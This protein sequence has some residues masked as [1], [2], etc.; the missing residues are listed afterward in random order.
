MWGK[1][2]QG[3]N[4]TQ[5]KEFGDPKRF[6]AFHESDANEIC[7]VSVLSEDIVEIHYKLKSNEEPVSPNLNIFIACFTTCWA[8]LRLY[9]ALDMLQER[10][11]YTDT[12]SVIFSSLPHEINPPL[13]DFLGDFK[14]ELGEDDFITE[15]A[16]GGPKNYG[17]L[18]K[19]EKEECKVR[20]ISL[21]SEGVKQLN[22]QVLRQNVL[23][24]IQR[25]LEKT[26]Q[27]DIYKPYHIVRNSKDYSLATV[28]QTKKY[29]LVYEK[30]V[31]DQDTFKTYPYGYERITNE[32][33]DMIELMCHL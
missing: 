16:S 3:T 2:G 10:V 8:R 13:D 22:Y 17:Y 14:D 31:I 12:D 7:Y 5:I 21:N 19:K 27:T 6:S 32:D 23:D 9:A 18:T 4:K 15:F 30:R 1:F 20:G 25:P 29:Q 11:L 28:A 24:E 26:R 33:A